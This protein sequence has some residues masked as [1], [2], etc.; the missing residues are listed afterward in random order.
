MF[1]QVQAGIS[2]CAQ[3]M[4]YNWFK[5]SV[6]ASLIWEYN[7]NSKKVYNYHKLPLEQAQEDNS[8]YVFR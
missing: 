6:I 4:F 3:D 1:D 7:I 2:I 8:S 5:T